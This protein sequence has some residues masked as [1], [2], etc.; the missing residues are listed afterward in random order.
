MR[1]GKASTMYIEN[2]HGYYFTGGLILRVLRYH[3]FVEILPTKCTPNLGV[4]TNAHKSKYLYI[5]LYN[6]VI[7]VF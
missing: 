3:N 2:T 1:A 4:D 6:S 5:Y 7:V